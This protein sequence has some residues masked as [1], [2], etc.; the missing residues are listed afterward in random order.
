MKVDG[1]LT[2]LGPY[3]G[4]V[5]FYNITKGRH[6][7]MAEIFRDYLDETITI[8]EKV[9]KSKRK[10]IFTV[11]VRGSTQTANREVD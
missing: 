11:K 10:M 1:Q 5:Y 8:E 9:L 3:D 2:D 6:E 7:S 4:G